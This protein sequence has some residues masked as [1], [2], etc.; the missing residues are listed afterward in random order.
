MGH[1]LISGVVFANGGVHLGGTI[2]PQAII[3]CDN[4]AYVRYFM[5][6]PIGLTEDD[7]PEDNSDG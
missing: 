6:V 7:Q 2:Y 3:V 1:H 5:A 4:C